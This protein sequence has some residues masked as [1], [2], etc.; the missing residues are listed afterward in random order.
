LRTGLIKKAIA[1]FASSARKAVQH[2]PADGCSGWGDPSDGAAILR[3]IVQAR[4]Q[5][6]PDL[7]N[8]DAHIRASAGSLLTASADADPAAA[9]QVRDRS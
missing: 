4:A 9:Q 7:L 5:F 3:S 2:G 1:L 8:P 6:I